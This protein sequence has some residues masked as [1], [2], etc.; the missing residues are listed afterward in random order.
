MKGPVQMSVDNQRGK[1]IESIQLR[2]RDVSGSQRAR[3]PLPQPAHDLRAT[4]RF[5]AA[6]PSGLEFGV[7]RPPGFGAPFQSAVGPTCQ[8]SYT[9]P[10]TNGPGKLNGSP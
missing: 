2:G 4:T 3:P 9:K 8:N 6:E 1:E 10:H 7:V 5:G